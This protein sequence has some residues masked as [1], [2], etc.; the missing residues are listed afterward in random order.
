MPIYKLIEYNHNSSKTPRNFYHFYRDGP[1]NPATNSESLKFK[2]R[3][4]DSINNA[5]IINTKIAVSLK[6]LN[7]FWGTG[8]MSLINF[9]INLILTWSADWIISEVDRITTFAITDTK[10]YVPVVTLSTQDNA[11][12]LHQL[13]IGFKRTTNWNKC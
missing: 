4:S 8:E 2:S 10:L 1:K 5:G 12:L 11:N 13:K 7:H 6:Y 3:L 9:E